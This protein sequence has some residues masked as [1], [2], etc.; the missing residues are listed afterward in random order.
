MKRVLFA[1]LLSA[2]GGSVSEPSAKSEAADASAAGATKEADAGGASPSKPVDAGATKPTT[3]AVPPIDSCPPTSPPKPTDTCSTASE[4]KTC[5]YGE[6]QPYCVCKA[7]KWSC[8][9][10]DCVPA[11]PPCPATAVEEGD[12]C[13][14]ILQQCE[15]KVPN[16]K[17][18]CI[19]SIDKR[20]VCMPIN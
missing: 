18:A 2:C 16:D 10:D 11:V 13:A 3:P 9:S 6:C 8:A 5:D 14:Q 20:W 19:C 12:P 15:Y 1:F 4:G 17:M 7:G